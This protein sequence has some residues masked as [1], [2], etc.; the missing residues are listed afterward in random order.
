[1]TTIHSCGSKWMGEEPDSIE[2]L[3]E[4]LGTEPLSPTFEGYGNFIYALGGPDGYEDSRLRAQA[5]NTLRFFGNF[6]ALS[7]GFQI[8]SDDP[9]DIRRLTNAIRANQASEGYQKARAWYHPCPTCGKLAQFCAC[10]VAVKDVG[11]GI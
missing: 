3:I 7:H 9:G 11:D 2:T 8:D 5:G 6:A 10:P 1:M 4:V